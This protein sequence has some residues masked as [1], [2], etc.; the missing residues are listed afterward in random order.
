MHPLRYRKQLV[1]TSKAFFATSQAIGCDVESIL[2]DIASDPLRRRKRSLRYRKQLVATSKAF[3]AISQGTRCDVESV[4]CDIASDRLRHRRRPVAA[5]QASFAM[6]QSVA[7]TARRL[8]RCRLGG[9]RATRAPASRWRSSRRA[10]SATLRFAA[11]AYDAGTASPA[12]KFDSRDTILPVIATT[13]RS[14]RM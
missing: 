12:A 1:A 2:C 11:P 14:S 5:S 4:P 9:G 13:I 3:F 8:D 10:A 7:P 6:P